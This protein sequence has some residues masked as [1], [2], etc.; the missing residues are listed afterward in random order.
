V[1][2][3]DTWQG[4]QAVIACVGRVA[5]MSHRREQQDK[6]EAAYGSTGEPRR[7]LYKEMAVR[8]G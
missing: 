7:R 3:Q 6:Q 2:R 5:R 1:G 4:S 8:K